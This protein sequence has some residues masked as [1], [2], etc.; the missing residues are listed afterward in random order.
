MD[1]LQVGSAVVHRIEEWRGEFL[2][3]QALFVGFSEES[4]AASKDVVAGVYLDAKTDAIA[5]RL[6]SWLIEVN[7]VRVLID[8][9]AGNDKIRPGIP[10]FGNLRTPFMERLAAAGFQ[11]DDIDMVICTHLHVDHVGWNTKLELGQWVPTFPKARYIFPKPDADYWDPKNLARYPDKVG[12]AVNEGFFVDSVQPILDAGKA[13]LVDGRRE[14]LT[15][16]RL[17]PAPGHT[18]GSQTITLT[19]QGERAIFVGDVVHHPLQIM[20]PRW[21]SIFC[22]DA[23]LARKS[24]AMVLERVVDEEAVMIPAH[25]A[26]DNAV[27]IQR[28]ASGLRPAAVAP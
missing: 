28:T 27:R 23:D 26:G 14:I 22:E 8:T 25:F 11:P 16:L 5:A 4:Y 9:G 1:K 18:P 24:R 21:N 13:E 19:S 3:P 10:L 20:N 7:G 2:T 12:E 17:D 6:Q 15:G